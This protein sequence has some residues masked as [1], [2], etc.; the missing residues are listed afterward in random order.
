MAME[1][2]LCSQQYL[3]SYW[4]LMYNSCLS[5]KEIYLKNMEM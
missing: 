5:R 4:F 1:M 3:F 2:V